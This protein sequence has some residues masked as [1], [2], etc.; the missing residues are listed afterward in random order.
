MSP[1]DFVNSVNF[2]KENLVEANPDCEDEYVPYFTNKALSYFP[3]TIF[4]SQLMNENSHI[5][6][7]L[8]YEYLLVSVPKKKRFSKWIKPEKL[9]IL[10]CLKRRYH[11][12]DT[13]AQEALRCLTPEQIEA[14]ISAELTADGRM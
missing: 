13:K 14:M 10:E 8:Q 4:H 3:D 12:N 11:Y 9:E 7:K 2:S 6:K 1:F 5:G